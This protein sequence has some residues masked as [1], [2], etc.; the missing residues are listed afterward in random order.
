MAKLPLKKK[1]NYK[2]LRRGTLLELPPKVST[3]LAKERGSGTL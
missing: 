1:K 2:A 3:K